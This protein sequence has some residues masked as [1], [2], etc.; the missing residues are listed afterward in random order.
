ME[1][2]DFFKLEL[3]YFSCVVLQ[4]NDYSAYP[5]FFFKSSYYVN[6]RGAPWSKGY[7]L[8]VEVSV[9]IN[10]FVAPLITDCLPCGHIKG[11]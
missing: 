5:L 9:G 10:V 11:G 7:V 1:V 8:N 4:F 6:F 2:V 3:V